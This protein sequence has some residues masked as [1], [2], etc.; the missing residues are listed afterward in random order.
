MK[1][2]LSLMFLAL[3]TLSSGIAWAETTEIKVGIF[4]TDPKMIEDIGKVMDY[5]SKKV[6]V[7]FVV[8][9]SIGYE[10][11]IKKLRD[12]DID[13]GI[14]GSAPAFVSFKEGIAEPIARPE[15]R[16]SSVYYGYWLT[17]KES[18][19]KKIEDFKGKRFAYVDP[20]TSAGYLFPRA[21]VK[22]KGFDPDNFFGTVKFSKTHEAAI[23][24]LLN[25]SVDGCAAKDTAYKKFIDTNIELKDRLNII[26][27][28][29]PF[30]ER[31]LTISKRI[32]EG[33]RKKVKEALLQMDSDPEGKKVLMEIGRSG[34]VETTSDDF[35]AIEKILKVLKVW[36]GLE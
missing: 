7:K 36:K 9:P 3:I 34:Y 16:K 12:G 10:K 23:Q 14:F 31:T 32:D 2:M 19:L 30:P 35:A 22:G 6:G 4:T 33:I 25:G 17:L 5:V 27:V 21:A 13:A 29:G 11:S 15:I 24:M 20:Y 8:V 1:T 26:E 28:G 18:G